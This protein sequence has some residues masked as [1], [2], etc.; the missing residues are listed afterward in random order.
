VIVD[1]ALARAMLQNSLGISNQDLTALALAD[2]Q[3][4]GKGRANAV[5]AL[6]IQHIREAYLAMSPEDRNAPILLENNR[7]DETVPALFEGISV[8]K[9]QKL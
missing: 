2:A 4:G 9:Y 7:L 6:P 1:L 8:P 5:L 3:N